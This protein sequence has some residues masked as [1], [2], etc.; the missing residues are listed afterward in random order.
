MNG[1]IIKAISGFYYVFF[2]GQ[3]YECKAR[4][5]FRKAEVS[6]VVGDRVEFSLISDNHGIVEKILDRKNLL[7]R[8][9]IAN[10]D[11]LFIISAYKTPSPDLLM[12]DRL[13]AV[14]AYHN[15][16]PIVVFNKCDMGDFSE[17]EKIYTN[18]G[19]KTYVVSAENNIG[20]DGI[21][22]ELKDCIS[23]FS[24]NSGVGKS[25]I[26]NAVFSDFSLKTGEVSEKLGRGRHTTRHTELYP[27]KYGGFVADTPGFSSFEVDNTDYDFKLHLAECFPEFN[28][29]SD[30]CRFVGCSHTCE[31]G[32]AVLEAVNDGIIE[33]SRHSSYKSIY[34][35]L[36]DLK[37]WQSN[38]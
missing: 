18:S 14:C 31:K 4:G 20:L 21:V 6:P 33:K 8:P 2:D 12:I 11:K 28:E 27:H 3:I 37:Q 9:I 10:I 34:D 15:I 29:Y 38:K 30:L 5:N 25:S 32:C 35:E 36:K 19:F 17:F 13:T 22:L 7:S 16:E 26:L 1:I 24:G 23:A